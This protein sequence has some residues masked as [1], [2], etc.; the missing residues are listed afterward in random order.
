MKRRIAAFLLSLASVLS[1]ASC[2]P[3]Q[4]SASSAP[5]EEVAD[6]SE[7]ARPAV[8][9]LAAHLDSSFHPA[10]ATA[11]VN[12]TLAPLLYESLF[13]LDET[14]TP[15]PLLCQSYSVTPDQLTWT[16][17][18]RSGVT[19]SDGT[20]LTGT[21][22]AEAL[23]V[24]R[25]A[26]SRYQARLAAIDSITGNNTQVV[27]TLTAPNG[28]LPALLDIPIALGTEEHPLGTGAYVLDTASLTVRRDWWQGGSQPIQTISLRTAV[29]ADDLIAAFDSGDIS[30]LDTDLTTA[31]ALGYSGNYEVWDYNT[32]QL[33]Y[34]GFNT[35]SGPCSLVEA[36]RALA[37]A[38]DRETIAAQ[39]YAGHAQAAALP[40]HPDSPW[41]DGPLAD[42][43]SYNPES[44]V[45][46]LNRADLAGK[47]LVLLVN[48]ENTARISAA[49]QIAYQ[50]ESV[51]LDVRIKSLPFSEYTT[52]LAQG[53][54]DLYLAE[55]L[56]P[57]D[58]DL[59][60]LVGTGGVVNYS[61]W[62]DPQTDEL[63]AAFRSAQDSARSEQAN[64]LLSHLVEQVPLTA[65]GFKNGSLL[66]QWGHF[67]GLSP[68]QNNIFAQL[69]HWNIQ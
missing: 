44:L 50:L 68:V 32:S 19:F 38:I 22:V 13:T 2:G 23:E 49:Q 46:A 58:F 34:L 59:T 26:G 54:F 27:I 16:F 60:A 35:L 64:A 8:L 12:L 42:T 17:T 25:G 36:R 10:L 30:L 9:T 20:S 66:T 65:V 63:L 51:G 40:V 18:L 7:E 55:T 21:A 14:F 56:L 31:N 6:S 1:L 45:S 67:S 5:P 48:S 4:P 33:I 29:H 37:V 62:A 69:A 41:Y 57:A 52:A 53:E 11:K 43:L 15:Q 47:D 24:A 39:F 61:F 28:G 3:S